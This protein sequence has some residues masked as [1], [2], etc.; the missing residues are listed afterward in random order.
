M[1]L[2]LILYTALFSH[3]QSDNSNDASPQI[4]GKRI[5]EDHTSVALDREDIVYAQLRQEVMSSQ[6]E[7]HDDGTYLN[8]KTLKSI[9]L[10]LDVERQDWSSAEINYADMSSFELSPTIADSETSSR[11]CHVPC[12]YTV[13]EEKSYEPVENVCDEDSDTN[14]YFNSMML[15]TETYKDHPNVSETYEPIEQPLNG[16]NSYNII[17]GTN[18]ERHLKPKSH[19]YIC[20]STS[21]ICDNFNL[22]SNLYFNERFIDSYGALKTKKE[23]PESKETFCH[24]EETKRASVSEIS[25]RRSVGRRHSIQ[26]E[27]ECREKMM[28]QLQ[29][30]VLSKADNREENQVHQSICFKTSKNLTKHSSSSYLLDLSVS[31]EIY[32]G[33]E[34]NPPTHKPV[35]SPKPS[36][37]PRRRSLSGQAQTPAERQV[38]PRDLQRARTISGFGRNLHDVYYAEVNLS[39]KVKEIEPIASQYIDVF[40]NYEDIKAAKAARGSFS[41]VSEHQSSPNRSPK[42]R[43]KSETRQSTDL[44]VATE[45]FKK[46]LGNLMAAPVTTPPPTAQANGTEPVACDLYED[47]EQYQN[48]KEILANPRNY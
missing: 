25:G 26:T 4:E 40:A 12:E 3:P 48:A 8:I 29:P 6:T 44:S 42:C 35:T 21:N 31:D 2:L 34:W 5:V 47:L 46:K 9:P 33:I 17:P 19:S 18:P 11:G 15:F 23:L 16:A 10:S 39:S 13:E 41:G 43:S 28:S 32:E 7:E 27:Y 30:E 24:M 45:S 37:G 1:I 36:T 38:C 14:L 20:R 22:S